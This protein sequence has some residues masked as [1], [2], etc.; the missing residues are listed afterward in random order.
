MMKLIWLILTGFPTLVTAQCLDTLNFPN[1]NPGSGC[2]QDFNPV[3]GCDGV[4]Y[5]N[6]C[7]AEYATVQQ[8]TDGPCESVAVNIYPNPATYWLYANVVTKFESNVRLFIFD[9]NGNIAYSNNLNNVTNAYLTIPVSN[10]GHGVYI[11]MAECNG[12][13][14]LLKFVRWE[15]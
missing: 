8:W 3:C 15:Q 10:L 14:Q 4:T 13:T 7:F 9:R 5:R 11:M 6:W 12:Y 2:H 1:L